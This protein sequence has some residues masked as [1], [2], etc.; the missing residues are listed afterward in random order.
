MLSRSRSK[1]LVIGCVS[2]IAYEWLQSYCIPHK[3]ADIT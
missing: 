2:A 3:A 1:T